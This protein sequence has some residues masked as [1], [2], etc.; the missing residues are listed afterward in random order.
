MTAPYAAMA[1]KQAW[2]SSLMPGSPTSRRLPMRVPGTSRHLV[3]L[4]MISKV[5]EMVNGDPRL[6]AT[7]WLVGHE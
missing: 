4:H 5:A 2:E 6:D 3:E 1:H 7:G